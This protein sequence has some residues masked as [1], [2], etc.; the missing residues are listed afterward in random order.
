[1]QIY[2]IKK[3]LTQFI[4]N[5][6]VLKNKNVD[7]TGVINL[8]KIRINKIVPGIKY[9]IIINWENKLK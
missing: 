8:Y 1:M 7:F 3:Y 4:G 6:Y 9:I 5:I 2:I